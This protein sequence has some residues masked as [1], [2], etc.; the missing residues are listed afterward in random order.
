MSSTYLVFLVVRV[1]RILLRYFFFYFL[2]HSFLFLTTTI[3]LFSFCLSFFLDSSYIQQAG[4]ESSWSS[5]YSF[6]FFLLFF[7]SSPSFPL[8]S[9]QNLLFPLFFWIPV[10]SP[11]YPEFYI[12]LSSAASFPFHS[13]SR[14]SS[15]P[16]ATSSSH[17]SARKKKVPPP[18]PAVFFHFPRRRHPVLRWLCSLALV[19]SR[20]APL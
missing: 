6:S 15:S 19:F 13:S 7:L 16:L 18:P 14:S 8:L 5:I 20:A 11:C 2:A 3:S 10:I 4:I 17:C 1:C 9:L 12:F